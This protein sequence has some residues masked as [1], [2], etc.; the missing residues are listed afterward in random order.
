MQDIDSWEG[1]ECVDMVIWD[2]S[3]L[4]AQLLNIS[5]KMILFT[6]HMFPISSF[7]W[8]ALVLCQ[9]SAEIGI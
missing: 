1:Y 5:L 7:S 9:F 3:G 2:F 6:L 8:K 4:S